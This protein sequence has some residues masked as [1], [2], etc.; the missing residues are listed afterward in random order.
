MSGDPV[1]PRWQPDPPPT[2]AAQFE[3]LAIEL[4]RAEIWNREISNA[5]LVEFYWLRDRLDRDATRC[6][7]IS[8]PMPI[9]AG[10]SRRSSGCGAIC[11][12]STTTKKRRRKTDELPNVRRASPM[13]AEADE[14]LKP[15]KPAGPLKLA[16][17][18]PAVGLEG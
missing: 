9:A 14:P 18:K 10:N 7:A 4:V 1:P 2:L 15:S 3:A 5:D 13:P 16:R 12:R 6:S 17:R 11:G 8:T